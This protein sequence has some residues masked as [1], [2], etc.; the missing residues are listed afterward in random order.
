MK[1]KNKIQIL[2]YM[3][4]FLGLI[5][6]NKN[7][8]YVNIIFCIANCI[9]ITGFFKLQKKELSIVGYNI[10]TLISCSFLVLGGYCIPNINYTVII[11][12]LPFILYGMYT[13]FL[14]YYPMYKRNSILLAIVSFLSFIGI[15]KLFIVVDN[16]GNFFLC[17]GNTLLFIG[18]ILLDIHKIHKIQYNRYFIIPMAILFCIGGCFTGIYSIM[19]NYLSWLLISFY[20]L[21]Y[22][23]KAHNHIN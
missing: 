15:I 11:N 9:S 19:C 18:L 6:V 8:F 5:A 1:N 21:F 20:S 2:S 17:A 16:V 23:N 22:L 7:P 12:Q 3:I 13:I 14:V 4:T 10:V